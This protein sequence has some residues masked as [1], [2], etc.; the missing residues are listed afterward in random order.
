M[1]KLVVKGWSA[2]SAWLSSDSWS[3]LDYCQRLYHCTYLR[4]LAL[5]SIADSLVKRERCELQL[6]SREHAEALIYT[7]ESSGAQFEI[8]YLQPG[9]VISLDLYRKGAEVKTVTQAVADVR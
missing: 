1:V 5:N 6:V 4:G 8:K 2:K 3:H 7:L 9:K